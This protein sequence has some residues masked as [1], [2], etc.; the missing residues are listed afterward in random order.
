LE[1]G[2]VP[3]ELGVRRLDAHVTLK[4]YRLVQATVGGLR[5]FLD[6]SDPEGGLVPTGQNASQ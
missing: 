5:V 6:E 2:K 1:T 4:L 3:F